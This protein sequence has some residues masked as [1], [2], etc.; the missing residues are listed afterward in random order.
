MTNVRAYADRELLDKVVEIGGVIPNEG[1]YLIIGVQSN[2]DAFNVF[3]DKFYVFDGP[4]FKQLSTG[5]TNSGKTALLFFK[6]QNLPG[7]A[8]WQTNKWYPDLYQR[9]M[10]K[11]SRTDGG[12]RALRQQKPI[13]FYRD[14]DG[15]TLAEEQGELFFDIIFANM[16]GVDYNPFS[17]ITREEI[18]GWS[19]GCQVWN[20]MGDYRQMVN[21]VWNRNKSVDYALLKEF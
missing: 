10:H 11:A 6:D 21:A 19:F 16:H 9:G 12:M 4:K 14:R 7:A 8:V 5:T 15:D 1:K 20:R 17:T 3:D 18:N 13:Y 2:E